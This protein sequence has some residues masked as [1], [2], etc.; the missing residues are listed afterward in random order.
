MY[1]EFD[2]SDDY[3]WDKQ[4]KSIAGGLDEVAFNPD[5]VT[6]G[7]TVLDTTAHPLPPLQ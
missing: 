2:I 4:R 3:M 5:W 1:R 7:F 6:A